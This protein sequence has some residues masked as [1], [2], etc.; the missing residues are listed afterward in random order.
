MA[1]IKTV[2]DKRRKKQDG[3]YPIII[4][5][6]HL[7]KST[8]I[9][10]GKSIEEKFWNGKKGRI[11]RSH[12]IHK[13]LNVFITKKEV[14]LEE[15]LLEIPENNSLKTIKSILTGKTNTQKVS[16]SQFALKT[17]E[18]E[19]Q[20]GSIGNAQVYETSF[21]RFTK[22][23]KTENIEF[24]EVCYSTLTKFRNQ[25]KEDGLKTN[26]ISVYLR[27]LRAIYNK[28]IKAGKVPSTSYPFRE[29]TI[30]NEAT[31]QKT[32]S[33]DKLRAIY[34]LE[35]DSKDPKWH[36]R[37]LFLLMY[38]LIG[39][40]FSDLIVLNQKNLVNGRIEYRR[41]KTKRLY[42]IKLTPIVE[43]ILKKYDG[44][45]E[46]ILPF[47]SGYEKEGVGQKKRIKQLLKTTNKHLNKI[48]EIIDSQTKITTYTARYS[49]ANQARE[50]GYPKEVIAE[51]LGHDYGNKVT[52]IYLD[53]ISV[54]KIDDINLDLF[55]ML[56]IR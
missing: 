55:K 17:I 50:L 24:D 31:S 37:N 2:L 16:F 27:A 5:L 11:K 26:T 21:N 36:A 8:S 45:S 48:G 20:S 14:E 46:Y 49:W 33:I 41:K 25:L 7:G 47:I 53:S 52:S 29:L 28:A 1:T 39:I 30:K 35:F 13:K 6:T 54:K 43:E 15:K 40:N 44:D 42:S 18:N 3:T 22:F 56:T 10:T 12:P 9:T 32:I 51:A 4:R 38:G 34:K 19:Y 23:L